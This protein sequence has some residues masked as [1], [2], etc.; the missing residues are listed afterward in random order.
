MKGGYMS[1]LEEYKKKVVSSEKLF[2]RAIKVLPDG[3]THEIRY[4][5]PFP[6]YIERASGSRKW[7]VDGNEY[8]DYWMA[9]GGLLLGHCHPEVVGAVQS[10]VAKGTHYGA[11]HSLEVEWAEL[12]TEMVPSAEMVRFT[13]SGTEAIMLA[14]KLA[15]AYTGKD[16]IIKLEGGFHGWSDY[17]QVGGGLTPPYDIPV[18]RGIP[19]EVQSTVLLSPPHDAD[20]I[21]DLLRRH[22]DVA[23]VLVEPGGGVAS[24]GPTSKDYLQRLREITTKYSVV[25]I[26]DE[27]VTGF[28]YAPGGCQ[29]YWRVTPD[30]TAL[31][32]IVAGG[33][34]GAGAVTG[35]KDIM[36]YLSRKGD[37]E[38]DRYRRVEHEG[39]F[40]AALPTAAAGVT[41]LK[42]IQQGEVIP[43]AH[44]LGDMLREALNQ[45][46]EKQRVRC[47]AYGQASIIDLLLNHKCSIMNKCEKIT[48][49]YDYREINKFDPRLNLNVRYSMVLQGIDLAPVALFVSSAHSDDEIRI[50]AE[51]FDRSIAMMKQEGMI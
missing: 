15:R 36:E 20:Y 17:V 46:F 37:P 13:A 10:Q 31:G 8:I 43:R 49:T 28:R 32:K 48:C 40:N 7:D 29:E 25:L 30:L 3:V 22:D 12:I 33:M 44:R 5:V 38:W 11:C 14:I 4:M 9:H 23:C 47:C 45:V 35:K 2:K 1:V 42:I 26:F 34:P 16:K 41:T 24:R 27:V 18:S 51:A 6:P 39:T 50:T 21:L 19:T